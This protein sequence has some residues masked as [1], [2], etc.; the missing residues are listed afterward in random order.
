MCKPL[1]KEMQLRN[2]SKKAKKKRCKE[3]GELFTP[4]RDLQ[5]CCSYS[6]EVAYIDK[7]L[8]SLVSEGKKI[9]VKEANKKKK[10]SKSK[11]KQV[12][13]KLA[14]TVV[15]KYVRLRDKDK[16]CC[17]CGHVEGRQ[18]HAGHFESAGGN[19]HQR[20]YT[21]NIHKQCSICNNHL[22]GNLVSYRKFMIDKYGIEKT[23]A[24]ENDHSTKK[25]TVEY[26]QKLIRVFKKKIRLYERKFR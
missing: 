3:C 17:S 4:L 24:I 2:N 1:T 8:K 22:S 7:N 20:F 13:L 19:Q 14:Q 9:R 10:E 5:P 21:L 25:Y 15:N 6:C 23:E 12:L 26:L 16:P 11:D 18:F